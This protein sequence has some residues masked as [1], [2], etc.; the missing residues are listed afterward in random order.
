MILMLNIA[1]CRSSVNSR[2]FRSFRPTFPAM[3][4]GCGPAATPHEVG[5]NRHDSAAGHMRGENHLALNAK[6][7]CPTPLVHESF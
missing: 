4:R 2:P 7:R 6:Y 1:F 5:R 3:P